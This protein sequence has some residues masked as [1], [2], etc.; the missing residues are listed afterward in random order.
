MLVVVVAGSRSFADYSLLSRHLDDIAARFGIAEIVSGCCR[1]ADQLGERYAH[2]H[3]IPIRRFP[4][5][6]ARFGR[7]AGYRRNEQM[8]QY[9]DAC[10]CFWVARSVGTAHMIRL[11]RQ[12][13]LRLRVV[14]C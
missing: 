2:E 12:Y 10:V 11:A 13:G 3:G 7:S 6:W 9:A 4:A 14:E 8:A 1:G 5:D